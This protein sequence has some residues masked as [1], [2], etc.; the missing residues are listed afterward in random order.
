MYICASVMNGAVTVVGRDRS[1]N[2]LL[3][4]AVVAAASR[5]TSTVRA[6]RGL[7][8]QEHAL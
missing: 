4:Y 2:Y 3:L 6:A 5:T 8:G 1:W 7:N